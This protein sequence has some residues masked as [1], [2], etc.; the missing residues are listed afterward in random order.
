VR[1]AGPGGA[2]PCHFLVVEVDAV[3]NPT[4]D[5]IHPTVEQPV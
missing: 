3:R 1:H 5:A 4:S 2:E